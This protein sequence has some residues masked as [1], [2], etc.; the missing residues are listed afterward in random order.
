MKSD[1]AEKLKNLLDNMSQEQFDA[2]WS[3]IT[4]LNLKGPTLEEYFTE[5]IDS[6]FNNGGFQFYGE[7]FNTEVVGNNNFALAA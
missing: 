6:T 5:N 3:E 4:A 2:S 7:N 1:L